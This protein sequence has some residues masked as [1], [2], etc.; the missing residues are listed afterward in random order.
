VVSANEDDPVGA[1]ER[2]AEEFDTDLSIVRARGPSILMALL[3]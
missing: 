3:E 2:A 1:I